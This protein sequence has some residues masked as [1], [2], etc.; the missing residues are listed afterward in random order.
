MD[1]NSDLAQD[2]LGADKEPVWW[3]WWSENPTEIILVTFILVFFF[4]LPRT[5]CGITQVEAQAPAPA[6]QVAQP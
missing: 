6:D 4:L 2:H 5:G 3:D 1:K